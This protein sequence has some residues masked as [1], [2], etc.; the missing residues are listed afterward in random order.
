MLKRKIL[1]I[2]YIK[3]LD[4]KGRQYVKNTAFNYI[5]KFL[6]IGIN[7]LMIPLL[8][9]ML[10]KEKFGVWQTI[11]S[12]ISF[13]SLLNFGMGNGLR[14][15]ITKLIVKEKVEEIGLAI[16]ETIKKTAL[17]VLIGGT[18]LLPLVYFSNPSSLF[19]NTTIE[20]LEIK[21]SVL[22]VLVFFLVNV[23]MGLVS[24]IAFGYQQSYINSLMAFLYIFLCYGFL[25]TLKE[26]EYI[27]LVSLAIGF[28]ALQVITHFISYLYQKVTFNFKIRFSNSYNLKDTTKLSLNFFFAQLLALLFVTVDNFVISSTLG[29]VQTAEFSVVSKIYFTLIGFFSVLLIQFWNN[30]TDAYEN[31]EFRWIKKATKKLLWLSVVVLVVGLI[32]SAFQKSIISL[33]LQEDSFQLESLT[34]ILFSVY[35]FLF[36]VNTIF[37]NIQ[38]GIGILKLQIISTVLALLVYASCIYFADLSQYGYNALLVFKIIAT[39]LAVSMNAFILKKLR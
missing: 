39:V 19:A 22:F 7:L 38:N 20:S 24:S 18:V 14:N 37:T 28:G 36:C 6:G 30:V 31:L 17:I 1:N 26:S 10:G 3:N 25:L 9:Q 15:L 27:N 12:A 23:V 29:P 33:W 16:G 4:T 21:T 13:I 5:L 8:I 2:S 11:L 32:I 34:F 35:T